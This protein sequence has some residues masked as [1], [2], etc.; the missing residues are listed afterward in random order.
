MCTVM[1]CI[2]KISQV[3]VLCAESRKKIQ[4]PAIILVEGP[5]SLWEEAFPAVQS[6]LGSAS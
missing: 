6:N 1:L 3:E 5:N 4:D 2:K